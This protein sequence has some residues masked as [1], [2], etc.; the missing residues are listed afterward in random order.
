MRSEDSQ[1]VNKSELFN[2]V[3]S[4]KGDVATT[5]E[6]SNICLVATI[7]SPEIPPFRPRNLLRGDFLTG[8]AIR[9][10]HTLLRKRNVSIAAVFIALALLVSPFSATAAS[11]A[12]YVQLTGRGSSMYPTIKEGDRLTIQLCTDG[13]LINVED[14]IAYSTIATGRSL[15]YMW[16]G[17]R[18]VDKYTKDGKWYFKTKGDNNSETDPWEV[19]EYWLLGIVV[20]IEHTETSRAPTDTASQTDLSQ[21]T[22]S[23]PS[24]VVGTQTLLIIFGN[25]VLGTTIAISHL[26]RKRQENI[27]KK[28]NI[29]SCYT[30]R[31][32]HIQSLYRTEIVDGRVG[33]RKVKDLSGGFCKSLNHFVGYGLWG[34]FPRRNCERYKPKTYT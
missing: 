14:I 16:I 1:K 27:L 9:Y 28:A 26:R 30:C 34:P 24:F 23:T 5:L 10:V 32:Y 25:I 33:L 3:W 18:V 17:H 6:R 4:V 19:P 20:N 21:T 29:L 12:E 7:P 8:S 22:Y 31:H 13:N 11:S 15:D 2:W